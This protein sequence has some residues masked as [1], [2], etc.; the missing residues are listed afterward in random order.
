[1]L[2]GLI[3]EA[4]LSGLLLL[5]KNKIFEYLVYS[6]RTFLKWRIGCLNI[7]L[8]PLQWK[9]LE[10]FQINCKIRTIFFWNGRQHFDT[11]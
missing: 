1:M 11:Y 10:L 6:I 9:V 7:K 4:A 3:L 8:K 2:P 5:S